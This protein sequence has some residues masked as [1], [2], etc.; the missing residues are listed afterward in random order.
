[1]IEGVR[2]KPLKWHRDERGRLME[3]LRRDDEIFRGFGQV[4]VTVVNPGY[5]KGWHYH[6]KQDDSFVALQ[7]K[8]RVGLYDARER[9]PTRG[10]VAEFML[11][12]EEPYVLQIPRGIVHGFECV[13]EVEAMVMNTPNEPYDRQQPDEFRIDPFKNDIPFKWH[14]KRG[15]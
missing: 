15:G 4:Y 2:T 13:G 1:M 12:P 6:Q 7:G 10:Q 8:V 5:V 14:A 9:S 11:S 3:I